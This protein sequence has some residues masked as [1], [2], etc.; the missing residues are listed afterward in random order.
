MPPRS[1]TMW[2]MSVVPSQ[3]ESRP[4]TR[5]QHQ[6]NQ[7]EGVNGVGDGTQQEQRTPT[8]NTNF[9]YWSD[10]IR[11]TFPTTADGRD[12]PNEGGQDEKERKLAWP[13]ACGKQVRNPRRGWPTECKIA[14]HYHG[15]SCST[16]RARKGQ[17]TQGEILYTKAS[18]TAEDTQQAISWAIW[19]ANFCTIWW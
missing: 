19:T 16:F 1:K 17:G 4:A 18:L 11:A 3:A 9:F 2:N 7:A 6:P 15:R 12:S 5:H 13:K 8:D 14:F 10:A